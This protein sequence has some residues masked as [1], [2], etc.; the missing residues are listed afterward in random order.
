MWFGS[1]GEKQRERDAAHPTRRS[2]AELEPP[3]RRAQSRIVDS[4]DKGQDNVQLPIRLDRE[5]YEELYR[6]AQLEGKSMNQM[7]K[8]LLKTHFRAAP[9]PRRK[10]REAIKRIAR[11]DKKILEALKNI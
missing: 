9:I 3:P 10:L 4:Y 2:T 5:T 11:D 7:I 8:D 6:R 1:L